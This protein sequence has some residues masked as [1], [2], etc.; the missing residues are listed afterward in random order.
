MITPRESPRAAIRASADWQIYARD[1]VMEGRAWEA[2]HTVE[3]ASWFFTRVCIIALYSGGAWE[4]ADYGVGYGVAEHP[5]GPWRDEWHSE[6]PSVLRRVPDKVLGPGH[7]SVVV[8]PDGKT[9]FIV[10][11]AWDGQNRAPNVH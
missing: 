11:H 2:W 7:N 1:R 5:L 10:Y 4:T 8:G 6:G 3:G 9:Q